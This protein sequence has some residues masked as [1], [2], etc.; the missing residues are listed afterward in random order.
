MPAVSGETSRSAAARAESD[1]LADQLR[2]RIPSLRIRVTGVAPDSVGV[3]IDGAVIPTAALEAPRFVNP[4]SHL[5]SA[6]SVAGGAAETRVDLKEGEA[7]DVELKIVLTGG[8]AP[9]ASPASTGAPPL[10]MHSIEP[11]SSPPAASHALAW[12]LI[13]GGGAVGIAGGV[14]MGIEAARSHDAAT[15]RDRSAF[16]SAKTLWTVG[17]IGAVAGG[18]VVGSG[19]IVAAVPA[20]ASASNARP[21]HGVWFGVSL[22]NVHVEGSW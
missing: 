9:G 13:A 3:T 14:L 11:Q 19:I 10:A 2:G 18:A 1:T 4:G 5:V 12:S 21:I 8:T 17:L 20:R 22:D 16:D 15:R 7:R 6:R